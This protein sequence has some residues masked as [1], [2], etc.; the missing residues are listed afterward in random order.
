MRL[1]HL[2]IPSVSSPLVF[3][4]WYHFF[5]F[6]T[7]TVPSTP[8]APPPAATATNADVAETPDRG[9]TFVSVHLSGHLVPE[10]QPSAAYRQ[11]ELLLGRVSDLSD[12]RP[13]TTG[14]SR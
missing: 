9:L 7:L 6:A 1:P 13:F 11:L 14:P 8:Q 2:P 10:F 5:F 3:P 4:L 12:T